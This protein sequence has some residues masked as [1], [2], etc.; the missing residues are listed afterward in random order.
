MDLL[1]L[2]MILREEK[3]EFKALFQSVDSKLGFPDLRSI[4]LFHE[5]ALRGD[6]KP[7]STI[8]QERPNHLTPFTRL[9]FP[10][11][12]APQGLGRLTTIME[13]LIHLKVK[14]DPF[15]THSRPNLPISY[16]EA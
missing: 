12:L 10:F 1:S 8:N 3:A 4:L 15:W 6:L 5:L 13:D 16:S 7:C 9:T 14:R 2:V 11:P